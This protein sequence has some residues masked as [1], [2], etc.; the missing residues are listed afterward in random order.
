M[1]STSILRF[2]ICVSLWLFIT[3]VSYAATSD[4][5][6]KITDLQRDVA[7][8]K[9]TTTLRLEAQKDALQK[10]LQ[11]LQSKIDQQDK[12]IG[13]ISA[14]TG[15]FSTLLTIFA[16]IVSVLALF[17]GFAGWFS[18]GA[19]AREE[20]RDWLSNHSIELADARK[21]V[22]AV[23]EADMAVATERA[24]KAAETIE[25]LETKMQNSS[26]AEKFPT[27][28]SEQ[29]NTLRAEDERLKELP[30]VQYTFNNWTSRAFA[31]YSAN[32]FDNASHFFLQASLDAN[33]THTQIVGSLMN[34][35][36]MLYQLKRFEDA[37]R[38]YDGALVRIGETS[39]LTEREQ[40]ASAL[41][42]KG[43][44]LGK[45]QKRAE[46]I[47][48]YDELIIRFS[49]SAYRELHKQLSAAMFNKGISLSELNRDNESLNVYDQL[50]GL[51]RDSIETEVQEHLAKAMLNKG[52]ILG[53]LNRRIEAIDIYDQLTKRFSN[54]TNPVLC[55]LARQALNG[56][57]FLRLQEAKNKWNQI[58]ARTVL[59]AEACCKLE[60]ATK[61]EPNA[62][63]EL[64]N[65]SYTIFLQGHET[66]AVD[67]LRRA[68]TLGGEDLFNATIKDTETDTVPPDAAFRA[69]LTKIWD[70]VK[71]ANGNQNPKPL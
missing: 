13:D 63:I 2:A 22:I 21:K 9:D 47:A 59:L 7:I 16:T 71:I 46:E 18:A 19:K 60:S 45:L 48:V 44:A 32:D 31:A 40:V 6:E 65:L 28:S 58:E 38:A 11:N 52:V 10:D 25:A 24:N 26:S 69:L 12:R 54:S 64:G 29:K 61:C 55:E 23:G 17:T 42:N 50:I 62:P 36:L 30:E 49:G 53:K 39:K 3:S 15:R 33:A 67:P 68:L 4:N 35:G 34:R 70:E 27:P 41:L 8:I 37:I 1:N 5:A 43:I 56:S 51:F 20:A 66:E 57:G 14:E